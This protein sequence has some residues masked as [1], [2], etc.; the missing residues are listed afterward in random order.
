[1]NFQKAFNQ[2]PHCTLLSKLKA[3][4]IDGMVAE[5]IKSWLSDRQQR[6]VERNVRLCHRGQSWVH[7]YLLYLNDI[8]DEISDTILKF[9][10]NTRVLG[11]VGKEEDINK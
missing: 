4:D 10:D 5:Q 11:K 6:K 9:T 2:V 3:H 7:S 8:D 1:M